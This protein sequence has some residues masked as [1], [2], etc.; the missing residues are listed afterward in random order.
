LRCSASVGEYTVRKLNYNFGPILATAFDT[1]DRNIL[2][3]HLS[4][5]FVIHG[6]VLN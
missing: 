1:I 5:Y 2:T 6:S 3:T 4:S